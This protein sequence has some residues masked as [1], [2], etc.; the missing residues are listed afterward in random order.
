MKES[1]DFEVALEKERDRLEK[2]DSLASVLKSE[3]ERQSVALG[4]VE[5]RLAGLETTDS[6]MGPQ[7]IQRTSAEIHSEIKVHNCLFQLSVFCGLCY[8]HM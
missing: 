8:T 7:D 3:C 6:G 2:L 4:K 1:D 5:T